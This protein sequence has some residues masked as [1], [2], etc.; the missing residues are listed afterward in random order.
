MKSKKTIIFLGISALLTGILVFFL[1]NGKMTGNVVRDDGHSESWLNDNCMCLEKERL[2]CHYPGFELKED[3]YCWKDNTF[4]NPL[5]KC[6]LYDCNGE[7]VSL[8]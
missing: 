1:F 6:S 3:K 5:K 8:R 7:N 4:T 2:T